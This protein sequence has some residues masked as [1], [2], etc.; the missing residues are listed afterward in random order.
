MSRVLLF[1][2]S[3]LV[4]IAVPL[5]GQSAAIAND[6]QAAS[7]C[8]ACCDEQPD[9]C[10]A[11]IAA[12]APICL[13]AIMPAETDMTGYRGN[14]ARSYTVAKPLFAYSPKPILPLPRVVA[15]RFQM[16]FNSGEFT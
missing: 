7:H 11:R 10:E 1:C 13:P 16:Q 4:L 8:L 14:A 6:H 3:A 15:H 5:A 12:C 2:L 9:N